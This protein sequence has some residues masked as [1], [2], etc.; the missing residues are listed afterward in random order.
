M[1]AEVLER[2]IGYDGL[3]DHKAAILQKIYNALFSGWGYNREGEPDTQEPTDYAESVAIRQERSWQFWQGFEAAKRA[4]LATYHH[5]LSI[6]GP[7]DPLTLGA[8]GEGRS[9]Y[10]ASFGTG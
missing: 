4:A 8:L 9:R 3:P 6:F 7:D 5:F 1:L 10:G 2:R